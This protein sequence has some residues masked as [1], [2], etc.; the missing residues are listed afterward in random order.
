MMDK[1]F[2]IEQAAEY[3]AV[4]PNKVR[5][6]L[7]KGELKGFKVGSLWRVTEGALNEFTKGGNDDPGKK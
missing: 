5:D 2:T 3:L 7:R 6:L 1:V 4:H